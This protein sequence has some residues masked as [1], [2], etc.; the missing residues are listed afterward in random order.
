MVIRVDVLQDAVVYGLFQVVQDMLHSKCGVQVVTETVLVHVIDVIILSQP[1]AEH[2]QVG[3][4]KQMQVVH[5]GCAQVGFI[6][7]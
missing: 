5:I 4:P 2:M 1:A 3:I 7:A 6:D